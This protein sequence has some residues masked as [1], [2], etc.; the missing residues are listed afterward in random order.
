MIE[1]ITN[2]IK[3]ISLPAAVCVLLL[4]IFI[5]K[6]ADGSFFSDD[7]YFN[8]GFAV[9]G[10]SIALVAIMIIARQYFG[11]KI[12]FLKIVPSILLLSGIAS[13]RLVLLTYFISESGREIFSLLI[14]VAL[15]SFVQFSLF[16]TFALFLL[17]RATL[18]PC[19]PSGIRNQLAGEPKTRK[20]YAIYCI[21]IG[22]F[23]VLFIAAIALGHFAYDRPVLDQNM[24][25]PVST[26]RM[27]TLALIFG[28]LGSLVL[29][30]G[31]ALFRWNPV[32]PND[33]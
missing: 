11:E 19:T 28:G 1:P 26:Q 30:S 32:S 21:A 16:F 18:G 12:R 24:G 10:L 17:P 27:L 8:V 31:I 23:M 3:K 29:A 15:G 9:I 22:S 5:S 7:H 13:V 25:K 33:R 2:S 20:R 6:P 4:A 14:A